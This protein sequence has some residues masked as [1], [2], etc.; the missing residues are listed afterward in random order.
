MAGEE[1]KKAKQAAEDANQ[2][3]SDFLAR[4]SHEIRTPMNAII[5]MSHL[6][7]QTK[8][9]AKQS[10]YIN[11]IQ[12]SS[13][14]LLSI[15][16]DILDFSKIEAGKLEIEET[17][18]RLD[19]VLSN[20]SSIMNVKAQDKGIEMLFDIKK[21]VPASLVGD[22]LRLGQILINLTNNALKFTEKGEII[23]GAQV[24]NEMDE[25]V[26]YNG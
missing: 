9:T 22:P 17:D 19:D 20:L 3:K 26:Y 14:S 8:L 23:V 18:F 15:I 24:E 25:T 11:K 13:H 6:I 2:A 7:L 16:N 4:M 12:S 1:L 10:D 5:G 21:D